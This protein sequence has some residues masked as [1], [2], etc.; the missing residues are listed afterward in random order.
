MHRERE[1]E[2]DRVRVLKEKLSTKSGV[3]WVMSLG[4]VIAWGELGCCLG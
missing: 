3:D 2:R 4:G 1:R